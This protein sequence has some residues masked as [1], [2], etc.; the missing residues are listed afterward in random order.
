MRK[1]SALGFVC[2]E[3]HGVCGGQLPGVGE[4]HVRGPQLP[5]DA[6][7]RA[8]GD[9]GGQGA[10]TSPKTLCLNVV[11]Q[12][13]FF[14]FFSLVPPSPKRSRRCGRSRATS[15]RPQFFLPG[16]RLP[17][18]MRQEKTEDRFFGG[19]SPA[20]GDSKINLSGGTHPQ[21]GDLKIDFSGKTHPQSVI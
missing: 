19:N 10:K 15:G 14:V 9:F 8:P 18:I 11:G 16:H 2:P 12:G 5:A 3:S 13:H 1:A 6:I 4:V 7:S 20:K 21:R 17:G